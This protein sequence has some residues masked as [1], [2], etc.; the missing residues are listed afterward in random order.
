M[1]KA[2]GGGFARVTRKADEGDDDELGNDAK[3]LPKSLLF[4]GKNSPH[5]AQDGHQSLRGA[6]LN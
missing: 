6:R 5:L 1:E 4:A 2:S 3:P